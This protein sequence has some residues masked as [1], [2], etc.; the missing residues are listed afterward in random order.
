MKEYVS[1]PGL[2]GTGKTGVTAFF[3]VLADH[4]VVADSDVGTSE[5]TLGG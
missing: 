5:N 4:S 2:N 3:F 1:I